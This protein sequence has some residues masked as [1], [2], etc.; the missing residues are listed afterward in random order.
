M[1]RILVSQKEVTTN[2]EEESKK[3]NSQEESDKEENS[4]EEK[5]A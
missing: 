4:Q 2:G 1:K 3:E 5:I